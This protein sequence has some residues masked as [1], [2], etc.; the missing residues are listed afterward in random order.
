[1]KQKID[2][3]IKEYVQKQKIKIKE[4]TKKQINKST[5]RTIIKRFDELIKGRLESAI[6]GMPSQPIFQETIKQVIVKENKKFEVM[7][8]Q[9]VE[10][11]KQELIELSKQLF[12]NAPFIDKFKKYLT[13]W[14]ENEIN[15]QVKTYDYH[16]IV[17]QSIKDKIKTE[18]QENLNSVMTSIVDGMNKKL[19]KDLE[20]TKKLC[21][22]IDAEVRHTCANLPIS[23]EYEQTI[24]TEI[25]NIVQKIK[26]SKKLLNSVNSDYSDED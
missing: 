12:E 16:A 25:M 18:F 1:M 21:Y 7:I 15:A 22:S 2:P 24:K 6:S 3:L 4:Y 9:S 20:I 10:F 8:N 14:I 23:Y 17:G 11:H 19:S 13:K 5:E 26:P